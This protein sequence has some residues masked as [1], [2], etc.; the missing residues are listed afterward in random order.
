MKD[1]KP[2]YFF[3]WGGKCSQWT[4][5]PFEEFCTVF[6]CTEQ[7]MMAGKAKLFNDEETYNAIMATNKPNEQKALGRKV[8][9]FDAD[10]WNDVARDIVTLGNYNKFSQNDDFEYFLQR[11]KH[12]HFVEASPYDKIWSV[13]L[14][15]SDPEIHDPAS[16]KGTNWLGECI[17]RAAV[18]VF[19]KSKIEIKEL[20]ERLNF[21]K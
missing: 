2:E 11:N 8:K 20:R 21:M 18:M 5:A 17:N 19:S 12:K 7:F 15:A 6:N 14:W 16:W 9:N 3:F 13:G 4:K 1:K 10:K